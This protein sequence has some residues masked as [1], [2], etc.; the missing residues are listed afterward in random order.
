MRALLTSGVMVFCLLFAACGGGGGSGGGAAELAVPSGLVTAPRPAY[1]DLSWQPVPGV[2]DYIVYVASVPD[3]GPDNYWLVPN[4]RR[5][6]VRA[7]TF[8]T[9][10]S[11]AGASTWH[12]RVGALLGATEGPLSDAVSVLLPPDAPAFV[13]AQGGIG[14]VELRVGAS[15]GAS[16][17]EVFLAASDAVTSENYLTLPE[18]RFEPLLSFVHRISGLANERTYFFVV[19]AR[20][21]SGL[22]RDSLRVS[23]TPSL[24]GSFGAALTT[25]V[26]AG[27][28]AVA[29]A[30]FDGDGRL[31]LATANADGSS[32]SV[33]LGDG[34]GGFG[35]RVDHGVG[36]S[37]AGILARD[38]S[39]DGHVDVVT[40]NA[41]AG[42]VSVLLGD[43]AGG[44]APAVD[45]AAGVRVEAVGAADFDL[46][47]TVDLVVADSVGTVSPESAGNVLNRLPGLG[48]GAF[49]APVATEVGAGPVALAVADFDGDA[50][51]DVA[52]AASVGGTV[53][54]LYGDGTG[55]FPR[56]TDVPTG[57][58][59]RSIALGDF[60]R[61][62]LPDVAAL[63]AGNQVLGILISMGSIGFLPPAY[64]G[65]DGDATA[66]AV[67]DVDGDA[68]LDFLVADGT[69]TSVAVLLGRSGE[70]WHLT[71]LST[72]PIPTAM[73][74]VDVDGDGIPDAIVTNSLTG[75]VQVMLGQG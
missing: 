50:F 23:A 13:L 40:A 39:G 15:A 46:D 32:V 61:D 63:A 42:T 54:V 25:G 21:A 16:E 72:A 57:L 49:D 28:I 12:A 43:G 56:R 65:T 36:G 30:D 4:G 41:D 5:Q 60:N 24:R 74:V 35:S 47:G 75:S 34:A 29:T 8:A 71:D 19:R 53:T 31:D 22:S 3:V 7:A 38:V 1:F 51:L 27:P 18:G 73:T 68:R 10:G 20:N 48:G 2:T 11:Y 55:A 58:D 37:P 44:F 66:F 6:I 64:M 33:L 67:A 70:F 17:Y 9:F 62:G 69:T 59:C 52:L 45:F 26:G 14:E